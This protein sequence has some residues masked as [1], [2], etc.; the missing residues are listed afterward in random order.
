MEAYVNKKRHK[1]GALRFLKKAMKRCGESQV[2]VTDQLKSC[3]AAMR[4]IGNEQR[5]GHFH[6]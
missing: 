4:E 2:I 5:H 3:A 6:I 1:A